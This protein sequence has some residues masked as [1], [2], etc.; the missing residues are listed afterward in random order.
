MNEITTLI[1]MNN[2]LPYIIVP[3]NDFDHQAFANNYQKYNQ[4]ILNGNIYSREFDELYEY[5]WFIIEYL[6]WKR[7]PK[8][9]DNFVS[10]IVG[11]SNNK[12][13]NYGTNI[14]FNEQKNIIKKY[15]NV[16]NDKKT[17]FEKKIINRNLNRIEHKQI[18]YSVFSFKK[19]SDD[20][21]QSH[22]LSIDFFNFI[23]KRPIF[24]HIYFTDND[25][26]N[27]YIDYQTFYNKIMTIYDRFYTNCN[28]SN[29]NYTY[30]MVKNATPYKQ[31]IGAIFVF[32]LYINKYRIPLM[33]NYQDQYF[34]FRYFFEKLWRPYYNDFIINRIG[35]YY[36]KTFNNKTWDK[37]YKKFLIKWRQLGVMIK[38]T[39]KSITKTFKQS[40][41][42]KE[43]KP[44]KV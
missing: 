22:K 15:L 4:E 39:M 33:R 35:T 11:F 31:L 17:L 40:T 27:S 20:I 29:N 28:T 43:P 16:P 3:E 36:L 1:S 18:N 12:D 24:A 21:D 19:Q 34:E 32:D 38:N 8:L 25:N 42:V 6:Q 41:N 30:N 14:L 13:Q 26:L 7:D 44:E 10:N 9:F 2:Y 37:S 5:S 23:K